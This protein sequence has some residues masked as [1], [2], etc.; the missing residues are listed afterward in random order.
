MVFIICQILMMAI[1][2]HSTHE[3]IMKDGCK[4]LGNNF[5]LDSK[6]VINSGGEFNC[7]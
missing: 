2:K 1:H 7:F 3:H 4:R 5:L 6:F